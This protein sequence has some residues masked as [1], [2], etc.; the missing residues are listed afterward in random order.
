MWEPTNDP[1][2]IRWRISM[3]GFAIR[4]GYG[5]PEEKEGYRREAEALK[6]RLAEL[7]EG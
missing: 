4:K 3:L 7:R 2:R 6:Q 5:S 1:E